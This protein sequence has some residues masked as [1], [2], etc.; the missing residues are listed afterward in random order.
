MWIWLDKN[1]KVE[2]YLTHGKSPVVGDTDFQIFAY[3][4]GLDINNFDTATIK[5]KKPDRQGSTY[6]AL[7]MT[8]TEM[9]YEYMDGDGSFSKFNSFGN[10]YKGF[11]FDFSDCFSSA[12]IV[13]LLDTPG[14]WE[15][16]IS[17]L[18]QNNKV[19]VSGLITFNVGSSTMDS[20][21]QSE[22]TLE[23]ILEN[24]KQII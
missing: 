23:Q 12:E 21:E 1:G 14:N 22:L 8:L 2:Q 10:P 20:E 5:F 13:K 16:T 24:S 9:K 18:S 17:I 3:F 11:L 6:D 7:Y 19:K 4:D 15:A